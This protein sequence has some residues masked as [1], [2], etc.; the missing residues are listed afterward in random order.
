[1]QYTIK[2]HHLEPGW[3][4]TLEH[5]DRDVFTNLLHKPRDPSNVD[6]LR[7]ALYSNDQIFQHLYRKS[8]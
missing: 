3:I 4:S 7:L 5:N 1:M 6:D 8:C 2:L